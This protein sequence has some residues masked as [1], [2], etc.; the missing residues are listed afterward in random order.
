MKNEFKFA[1]QA[2]LLSCQFVS[3]YFSCNTVNNMFFFNPLN[4][5]EGDAHQFLPAAAL[6]LTSGRSDDPN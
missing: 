6:L 4:D 1:E 3:P 5:A 2:R